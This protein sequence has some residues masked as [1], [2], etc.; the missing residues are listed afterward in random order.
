MK[1]KYLLSIILF[2]SIVGWG[3]FTYF[4]YD[5]VPG[6]EKWIDKEIKVLGS[7]AQ[8]LN[9]KVLKLSLAAYQQAKER[10]IAQ[11]DVLTI[12]DYSMPSSKQR[13]WV[14]DLHKNKVLLNTYVAHGKNSGDANTT[15]FSNQ[16]NSLK[17]SFGVFVTDEVYSGHHGS[18]L[19]IK[20]LERGINDNVFRRSVVFHGASYV[21]AAVAKARG[22][23]GRS[24]GC[25]AVSEKT[26][27]PLINVI[28]GKSV[29][30]AY[31]PDNKWLKNSSFLRNV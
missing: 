11:K 15:S 5:Q 3:P 1:M 9:P 28:K 19:R 30:F 13:L 8:N 25:M 17:S 18:S 14:I 23:L 22:K 4:N 7:Q 24:W 26:I 20:G 29:V 6:S 10:G 12:I 31:Y 21:S 2:L 27:K 16:P